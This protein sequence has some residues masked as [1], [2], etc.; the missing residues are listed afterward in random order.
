VRER[1]HDV[2]TRIAASPEREARWLNTVSL[3]EF[4]GARKISRTVADR[5]PSLEVLQHLA[6]ETR[7]ALAFKRLATEVAGREVSD[8]LCLEAAMTYFQTL[9]RA[10]AA[11]ANES[12]GRDDVRLNYL[13]TTT[14]IEQR[15]MQLYPIYKSTT[16]QR[17]VKEELGRIIAEEQSH[18]R[19]IEDLCFEAL[20][21]AG[22]DLTRPRAIE[23]RLFEGLLT[24]LEQELC[25]VP[26]STAVSPS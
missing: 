10:L 1:I 19:S 5:H 3:L 13:L 18:R 11:W 8:Y 17:V 26:A 7:H 2:L 6:D 16:R 15:A 12:T 4:T 20:E 23:A 22:T 25:L 9:D 14:L 24:A 21:S